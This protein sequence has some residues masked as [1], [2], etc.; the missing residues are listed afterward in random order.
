[1][2][3]QSSSITYCNLRTFHEENSSY[4]SYLYIFTKCQGVNGNFI[5]PNAPLTSYSQMFTTTQTK[6]CYGSMLFIRPS[7]SYISDISFTPNFQVEHTFC[8]EKS[9]QAPPSR[10]P[11]PLTTLTTNHPVRA[12]TNFSREG[13][14]G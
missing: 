8:T 10:S 11:L 13:R 12:S 9:N 2:I 5:F 14:A 7:C 1:M 6:E 4:T 3:M